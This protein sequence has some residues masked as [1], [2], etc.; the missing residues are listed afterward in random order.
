MPDHGHG[1]GGGGA[2]IAQ[3]I[4]G[5]AVFLFGLWV[6]FV[7]FQCVA[8]A[9]CPACGAARYIPLTGCA[10]NCGNYS[11]PD[12]DRLQYLLNKRRQAEDD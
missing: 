4:V 7:V 8:Q 3:L 2:D 10:R 9:W 5:T 6:I 11:G 12:N 1:G